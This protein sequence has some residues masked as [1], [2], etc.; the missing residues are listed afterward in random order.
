MQEG[1]VIVWGGFKTAEKRWIVKGKG[2][3]EDI[4]NWMQS[5]K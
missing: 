2:E 3:M 4:P 5:S 1:K